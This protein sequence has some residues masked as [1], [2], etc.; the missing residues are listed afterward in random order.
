VRYSVDQKNIAIT[1]ASGG[2][3]AQ[4]AKQLAA[5][6]GRVALI[7]RREDR[8]RKLCEE[9]AQ[10]GGTGVYALADIG[11]RSSVLN[12]V[13]DVRSQLGPI[14][15]MIANAGI[16]TAD[17]I[18]PFDAAVFEELMR[19]NWIGLIYSIEA[20]LPAMLERGE[21][22]LVATSSL[23]AYRGMPGFAGY[24]ATKAAIK[25]LMEG[26]RV[27]LSDRG[28]DVSVLFPGFVNTA[29]TESKNFPKPFMLQSDDAARRMIAAI[30]RRR[31]VHNFPWQTALMT[32]L[33]QVMPDWVIHRMAPRDRSDG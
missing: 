16:G 6:G 11:Q 19:V 17:A 30:E 24:G 12:A 26:L 9:I 22:Y 33:G 25:T 20:V 18:D 21:G 14:D 15:M 27:D 7:S 3:G 13:D 29:M 32:K 5:K 4:L 31:K 10:S 8:L 1:G 2:I 23:R 28:I